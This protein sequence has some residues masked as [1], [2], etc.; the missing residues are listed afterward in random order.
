MR[1][2]SSGEGLDE[3]DDLLFVSSWSEMSSSDADSAGVGFLDEDDLRL[4][5][6]SAVPEGWPPTES[7][8]PGWVWW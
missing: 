8:E 3:V 5:G 7:V 4:P 6:P 2:T 1:N